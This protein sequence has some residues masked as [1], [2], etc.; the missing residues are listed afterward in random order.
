V[1]RA[2]SDGYILE[3]VNAAHGA[4]FVRKVDVDAV[5]RVAYARLLR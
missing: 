1:V 2:A 3:S 4:R 5:H